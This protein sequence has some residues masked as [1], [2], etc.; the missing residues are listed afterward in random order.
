[1]KIKI[2]LTNIASMAA[3][4]CRL[5]GATTASSR[6]SGSTR[7]TRTRTSSTPATGADTDSSTAASA[8]TAPT[9]SAPEEG[10]FRLAGEAVVAGCL[11][12]LVLGL[13]EVTRNSGE[14]NNVISET[15][16]EILECDVLC[17]SCYNVT[18]Y[19]CNNKR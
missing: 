3:G 13:A 14:L 15:I 19:Q 11:A 18:S 4:R 17:L 12:R 8:A 10:A 7:R 2:H 5:L 1:M 16:T 6:M 9:T